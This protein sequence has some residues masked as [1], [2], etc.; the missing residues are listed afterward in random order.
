MVLDSCVL[1]ASTYGLETLALSELHQHK[2]QVCENNWIRK[3][4]GVRRVE[5]RRMKDLREEVGTKACIVGKIVKSRVKWA[6]HM[7]RMKD[8]ILNYRRDETKKQEGSRK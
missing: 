2:L 6:G 8:D 7:F 1:P 3:I 5:R 4:A